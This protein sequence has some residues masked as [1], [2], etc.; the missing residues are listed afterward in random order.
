MEHSEQP[1]VELI[2]ANAVIQKLKQNG[3]FDQLQTQAL[4]KLKDHVIS[5]AFL[6]N[7]TLT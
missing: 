5:D 1:S 7:L 6:S 4:Q 2:D 3:T